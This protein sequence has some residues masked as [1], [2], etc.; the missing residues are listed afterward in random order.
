MDINEILKKDISFFLKE[1]NDKIIKI[2]N[3]LVDEFENK[4][5]ELELLMNEIENTP[6]EDDFFFK[7]L[8]KEEFKKRAEV[9]EKNIFLIEKKWSELIL[10]LNERFNKNI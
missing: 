7:N 4:Q 10:V 5:K 6:I 1:K 9:I 3:S 2:I 8:K